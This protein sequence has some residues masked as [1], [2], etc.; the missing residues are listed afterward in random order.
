MKNEKLIIPQITTNNL[1]TINNYEL[2]KLTP[3]LTLNKK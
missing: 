3:T 2:Q 1:I